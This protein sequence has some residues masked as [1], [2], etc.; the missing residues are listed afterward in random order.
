MLFSFSEEQREL[1]DMVSDFLQSTL[2]VT[3]LREQWEQGGDANSAILKPIAELGLIG[4][5]IPEDSDGMGGDAID[6]AL[7]LEQFG[8]HGVAEAVGL[9]MGVIAPMVTKYGSDELKQQWL[10]RISAGE[11]LGTVAL[12][13]QEVVPAAAVADM[14]LVEHD[15]QIHL[16]TKDQVDVTAVTTMDR[17]LNAGTATYR[18][19]SETLL[20]DTPDAVEYAGSLTR[21]V[22]A[23][24]LVG[25]SQRLLDMT[26]DYIQ[27]REQF[28]RIIGS[29]QAIKHRMADTAVLIEAARSLTWFAHYALANPEED[30][31]TATRMAKSA[32]NEAADLANYASLQHHGGVGFT[33]EYD[34][35]FWLQRT[36]ALVRLHGDSE[37]L[38]EE[39]GDAYLE[40]IFTEPVPA[41]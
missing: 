34:V 21:A 20:T 10:P 4:I 40:R 18:L 41:A 23:S 2:P 36:F 29:F 25:A 9:T 33:W 19:G 27:T 30:I 17:S 15:G 11:L 14:I 31:E 1:R 24:T 13:S 12:G 35:H 39:L 22:I 3:A 8:Y 37:E 38:L 6:L 28:G 7:P 5:T 32:A 26:T 16:L